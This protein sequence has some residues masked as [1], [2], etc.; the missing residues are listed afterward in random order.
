MMLASVPIS[1]LSYI[2]FYSL[3]DFS[4]SYNI[5]KKMSNK[6]IIKDAGFSLITFVIAFLMIYLSYDYIFSTLL[7]NSYANRNLFIIIFIA[8]LIYMINNFIQFPILSEKK[9]F[10]IISIIGLSIILN[11]SYL[12]FNINSISILTPVIGLLIANFTTLFFLLLYKLFL[13]HVK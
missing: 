4:N 12:Y 11:L 7:N 2:T 5:D 6:I 3:T 13:R 8:N 10:I 1:I 9:Y